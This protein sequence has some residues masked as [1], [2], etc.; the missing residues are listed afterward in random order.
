MKRATRTGFCRA[1]GAVAA[2]L[3]VA[4][5]SPA[6]AQDYISDPVPGRTEPSGL[7][8]AV[9]EVAALTANGI[10]RLNQLTF[11]PGFSDRRFVVD[12]R[13]FV[14]LLRDGMAPMVYLNLPQQR[15]AFTSGLGGQ[16]GLTAIAFHPDFALNGR[17]YTAHAESLNTG[18]PDFT[19]PTP[20][21][22]NGQPIGY[23][24]DSVVREWTASDP[25]APVF[26]GASRELVRFRQ[27]YADHNIG[28]IAFNPNAQPGDPDRGLLY[29]A[30]GDGGNNMPPNLLR[31]DPLELAQALDRPHGKILRLVPEGTNG[32]GGR[33]GFPDDNPWAADGDA[34][35][36]GEIWALGLRNPHRFS[37]DRG[38]DGVMLISD[39]GQAYLEEIN[40]GQRGAN[41]GWPLREGTF[42]ARPEQPYFI[43]PLPVDDAAA[44]YVYPAAQYDRGDGNG[45]N[46]AIAGGFVYRGEAVPALRGHY[47]F[48]D[49]PSGRVFHFPVVALAGPRPVEI[50]ELLFRRE[51][52]GPLVTWP[53]LTG[54]SRPDLRFG[55]D[56]AGEL[57]ITNKADGKVRQIVA[58]EPDAVRPGRLIN[59]SGRAEVKPGEGVLIGGFVVDGDEPVRFAVV[60]RGP[61]LRAFGVGGVLADP[62]VELFD[63]SGRIAM[64]DSHLA[65]PAA[66]RA[67][68]GPLRPGDDAEAALVVTLGAGAYTVI[69]RGADGGSG[70]G[71]VEVYRLD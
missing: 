66:E 11:A 34:A 13:G 32:R 33:Y 70:V 63:G 60:A 12:M 43:Y 44:G 59:V 50:R 18:V 48:A 39:I 10:P 17:F 27:P 54:R 8:V 52:G 14:W 19:T 5:A 15:A 67:R 37:W 46:V 68:L 61:S 31:T 58:A 45:G 53:E 36:L 51:G 38:G 23:S 40:V 64:N 20:I 25:T 71:I 56:A 26:G 22:S 7:V 55:E 69:L 57:F 30:M 29:V 6:R 24:H 1:G 9:R 2:W 41:Y 47:V 42:L 16:V 28:L 4:L 65:L 49:F 35:T 21:G 3:A 62:V